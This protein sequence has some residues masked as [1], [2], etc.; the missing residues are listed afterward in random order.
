MIRSELTRIL[1]IKQPNGLV[2][3][4]IDKLLK[5]YGN[6]SEYSDDIKTLKLQKLLIYVELDRLEE[7]LDYTNLLIKLFAKDDLRLITVLMIQIDILMKQQNLEL[8][9]ETT[10]NTLRKYQEG[11]YIQRL[12]L[13][14]MLTK[15]LDSADIE[16]LFRE[17]FELIVE[18]FGWLNSFGKS[19]ISLRINELSKQSEVS[20]RTYGEFLRSYNQLSPES[21]KDYAT[22][23]IENEPL[24]YYRDLAKSFL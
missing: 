1:T 8:A 20:N 24:S 23:Y 15:L 18:Y 9:K 13:L 3:L 19:D 5:E 12:K 22:K 11:Y 7:A 16:I 10:I 21:R 4:K 14:Q 6:V 17:D 2:L